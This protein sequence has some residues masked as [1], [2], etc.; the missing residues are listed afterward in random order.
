MNLKEYEEG[1]IGGLGGRK[2]KLLEL[3][4]EQKQTKSLWLKQKKCYLNAA[5]YDVV[6]T[7]LNDT[8][9]SLSHLTS[10]HFGLFLVPQCDSL[11]FPLRFYSAFAP[12]S[13]ASGSRVFYNSSSS[14]TCK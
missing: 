2:W 11:G 9:E 12:S 14:S 5:T 1:Y 4:Y 13:I 8:Y 7:K 3:K 6:V 10:D